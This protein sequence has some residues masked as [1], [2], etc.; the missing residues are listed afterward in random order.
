MY[1]L[2]S[3]ITDNSGLDYLHLISMRPWGRKSTVET[4]YIAQSQCDQQSIR[5]QEE[6]PFQNPGSKV[7]SEH[8]GSFWIQDRKCVS[9]D[10]YRGGQFELAGGL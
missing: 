1:H 8:F 4:G 3:D 9:C 10:S 5:N 7:L 6:I 2:F